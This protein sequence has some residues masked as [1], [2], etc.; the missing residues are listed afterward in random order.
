MPLQHPI[1]GETEAP[2]KECH[3]FSLKMFM[4]TVGSRDSQTTC[5]NAA[6]SSAFSSVIS[7]TAQTSTQVN[8]VISSPVSEHT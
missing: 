2:Q 4:W 1:T 7:N 8:S 3:F 6:A 5:K